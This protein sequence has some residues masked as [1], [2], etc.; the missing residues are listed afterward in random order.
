M[1][2]R[3]V[4][5]CRSCG[6]M[7]DHPERSCFSLGQVPVVSF[8]EIPNAPQVI[9]PLN[10]IECSRCS[11]VQL[12]HSVDPKAMFRH[13]WYRSGVT[14]SMRSALK[15]VAASASDFV[16][17][18]TGDG[19]LDIGTNDG[20]LLEFFPD[21][22]F[23][24]GFEPGKNVAEIAA[25]KGFPIVNDFFSAKAIPSAWQR[26][27]K[28]VTA[29][30]MFYDVEDLNGF[31]EAVKLA[32]HPKGIFVV[33]MNYLGSMLKNLAVD[34]ICHEHLTYFSARAF[35]DLVQRHGM[36]VL[37]FQTNGVNGGSIRFYVGQGGRCHEEVES[38][39]SQELLDWDSFSKGIEDSRIKIVD[40]LE[41]KRAAICGAST[42][43]LSALQWLGL[44]KKS[45]PVAGDR[46]PVKHGRYY[47]AT[48]IPIVS[49]EEA[50][51]RARVLLVLPWHFESEIVQREK[52]FIGSG[53][54]LLFPLPRP[55]SIRADG[56]WYL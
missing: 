40:Y 25:R 44:G 9:A 5:Y 27:F 12:Q 1:S 18:K 15:D 13:F 4:F 24:A 2:F 52:R 31:M 26:Q 30:S 51:S 20:T 41:G 21:N 8:P 53:G 43:G 38:F 3:E 50:R 34:N 14:R 33:Q 37:K 48:G 17:L 36:S 6:E 45:L 42:R 19:V 35:G 55:K 56:E 46:D 47:G 11:L 49:E 28:I 10:L 29:I 7:L 23:R 54:E 22:A 39:V 32:L 16:H